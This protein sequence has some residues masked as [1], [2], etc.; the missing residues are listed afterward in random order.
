MTLASKCGIHYEKGLPLPYVKYS[1]WNWIL[2]FGDAKNGKFYACSCFKIPIKNYLREKIIIFKERYPEKNLDKNFRFFFGDKDGDIFDKYYKGGL[3]GKK[4]CHKCNNLTPGVEWCLPMYGG[5][6]VRSYGWYIER[7]YY[8][9]NFDAHDMERFEDLS[10]QIKEKS[11]ERKYFLGLDDTY[12]SP[13]KIHLSRKGYEELNAIDKF[14]D[15]LQRKRKNLIENLVRAEFGYKAIGEMWVNETVI[16]KIVKEL[17]PDSEVI[18]HY[19]GEELEGLEIDV[20]IK[21]KKIGIEYNGQQHYKPIKHFGGE[22]SFK[23]LKARDKKKKR[24]CKKLG[25]ELHVIKYTEVITKELI[26]NKLCLD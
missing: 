18:H 15:K 4:L 7:K 12:T 10:L 3:F 19:R 22:E 14:V 11:L 13:E 1:Q 16:L 5:K 24:L 8:E 25:I 20:F 6:F 17:M 21:D 2:E 23:K 9:R 26:K